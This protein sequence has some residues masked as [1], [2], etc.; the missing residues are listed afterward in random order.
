[1]SLLFAELERLLALSEA[2]AGAA[3]AQDWET[4]ARLG[5]ER[6]VLGDA[7]PQDLSHHLLPRERS[8]ARTIIERY[9]ALEL[10]TRSLVEERQASLRILLREPAT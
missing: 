7:L 6:A 10:R 4:L 5:E 2:M 3:E 8:A 9:Q 1:M